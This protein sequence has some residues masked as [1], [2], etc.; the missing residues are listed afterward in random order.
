MKLNLML[1]SI[2]ALAM[3]ACSSS[4]VAMDHSDGFG[5]NHDVPTSKEIVQEP[6]SMTGTIDCVRGARSGNVVMILLDDQT[7]DDS[8]KLVDY[9]DDL[10]SLCQSHE[11]QLKVHVTGNMTPRFLFW[12]GNLSVKSFVV[13]RE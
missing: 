7:G 5:R 3:T 10:Q 11:S 2:G 1:I 9:G 12:G 6:V 4:G 13:S 8:I